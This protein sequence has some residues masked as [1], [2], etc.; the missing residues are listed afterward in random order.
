MKRLTVSLALL[1]SFIV[2]LCGC[3]V[4]D[5]EKNCL[6]Y[7]EKAFEAEVEVTRGE[8][9]F[10]GVVKGGSF[11]LNEGILRDVSVKFTAP[12]TLEGLEVTRKEGV[13]SAFIGNMRFDGD[14]ELA[15]ELISF[16]ELFEITGAPVSMELDGKNTRVRFPGADGGEIILLLGS[17]NLPKEIS[18][19]DIIVRVKSFKS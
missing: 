8:F 6:E 11:D 5:G 14:S 7:E 10:S 15:N 1:F 13:V 4:S 9:V 2:I 19:G 18:S 17:D 12:S 16:T 3:S